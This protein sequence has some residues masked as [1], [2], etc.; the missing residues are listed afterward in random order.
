MRL[1]FIYQDYATGARNLLLELGVEDVVVIVVGKGESGPPADVVALLDRHRGAD[2]AACEVNRK[3]RK[4][5]EEYVTFSCEPKKFRFEDQ[6][7]RQWLKPIGHVAVIWPPPS[8]SFQ[9]CASRT[10]AL[11]VIPGALR[12]A[13]QLVQ[14]RWPFAGKGA[15]LLERLANGE[16][17]GSPREWKAKH[18]VEFAV[19]GR[20]AYDFE[21]TFKGAV[22]KRRTE[23]HLKEG[24]A[25][26][27]QG[28]ARIYFGQVDFPNGSRVVVFYVGPHP[29]DGTYNITVDLE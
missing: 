4:C 16:E 2:A 15:Q 22:N 9:Q 27:R 28:A 3:Y 25:T 1:L 7:L 13:D 11:F 18:G 20:V 6:P 26:T 23:W 29:Q 8:V 12:H 5:A 10:S 21:A 14:I 17:L 24:D 19:N